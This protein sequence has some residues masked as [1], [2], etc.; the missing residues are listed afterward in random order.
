MCGHTEAGVHSFYEGRAGDLDGDA[1]GSDASRDFAHLMRRKVHPEPAGSAESTAGSFRRVKDIGFRGFR[2]L[3]VEHFSQ[4][5][6][7]G[8]V[9]WPS[10][11]GKKKK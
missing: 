10:R 1:A 4:Q 9:H 3:L 6:A 5:W 2:A 8:N 7:L 11:N